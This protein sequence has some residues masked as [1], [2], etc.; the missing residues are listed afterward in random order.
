[1]QS[2]HTDFY[3]KQISL[4]EWFEAIGH[5]QAANM[6][7][8]DNEKRERLN[9]LNKIIGL[10]FD[11]P[12][13]F[14]AK[15]VADRSP[16]FADYLNAHGNE[17]CAVRLIPDDPKLPKLRVRGH[18]IAEGTKWF[19]EQNIDPAHYRVDFVPHS[20]TTWATIFIVSEQG[21]F[22][23]LTRGEHNEL[24]QG[25]YDK[26]EPITFQ[27]DFKNWHLSRDEPG[28]KEHLQEIVTLLHVGDRE[29][30]E[31]IEQE[32]NG[33]FAHDYLQ[34]YFETTASD[35]RGIW[36]IDY[37]RLLGDVYT[38]TTPAAAK[39]A[40]VTGRTGSAGTLTGTV[41]IVEPDE[42]ADAHLAEGDVLVCRMTSPDYVPLMQQ[43]GAIIT[44]LGG[45]LCHAA[46]IAR[47]L[48]KPCIVGTKNA[49]SV[50]KNGQSVFVDATN[51][52]VLAA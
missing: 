17:L 46:I 11:K 28:A 40:L 29:Q 15:E 36:F 19:D 10:P 31:Q 51:G 33:T 30:Q 9:V 37:N 1:M 25:L 7:L 13:Q 52:A 26:Y 39:D 32:L 47:E 43:A 14:S 4:T 3:A 18:S 42:L 49:T 8:E 35:S 50:L 45:A 22:G 16:A 21:I 44:D 20:T 5:P 24:T 27:Y 34:G 2:N 6:R 48:K 38:Q 12:T 41:I 23:E